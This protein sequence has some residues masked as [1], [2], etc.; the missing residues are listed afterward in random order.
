MTAQAHS[1][2]ASYCCRQTPLSSLAPSPFLSSYVVLCTPSAFRSAS[3]PTCPQILSHALHQPA[4]LLHAPPYTFACRSTCSICLLACYTHPHTP[5]RHQSTHSVGPS[6]QYIQPLT[7]SHRRP[8]HSIYPSAHLTHTPI[9]LHVSLYAPHWPVGMFHTPSYTYTCHPTRPIGPSAHFMHPHTPTCAVL[10]TP[11]NHWPASLPPLTLMCI[12]LH[13]P[14]CSSAPP[15]HPLYQSFIHPL[16]YPL[17]P[18]L[19]H[20]HINQLQMAS[21]T[22][23]STCPVPRCPTNTATWQDLSTHIERCHNNEIPEAAAAAA[24]LL[25]CP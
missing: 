15:P 5:L 14:V 17:F 6:A 9:H 7:P 16:T 24:G 12:T 8:T 3:R 2:M 23:R 25:H 4:G 22:Q 13:A 10:H 20:A 18:N 1:E 11:F 19:H 21:A